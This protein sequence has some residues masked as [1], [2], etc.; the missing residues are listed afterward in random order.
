MAAPQLTQYVQGVTVLTGDG[1][2]TFEQTCDTFNDLRAF[3]GT[4][5][6]EINC[7]GGA[8]IGDGLQGDFYWNTNGPGV[9]DDV[10]NIVP[11]GGG[12]QWTRIPMAFVGTML[13]GLSVGTN[14]GN[15]VQLTSTG[16]LPAVSRFSI[17][18][19]YSGYCRRGA[20]SQWRGILSALL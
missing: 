12:G 9:D 16:A 14:A 17:S 2:N 5:G 20:I 4:T 18:H 6:M 3:I 15:L 8:A 11:S 19:F 1:L 13:S 7:R 10:N